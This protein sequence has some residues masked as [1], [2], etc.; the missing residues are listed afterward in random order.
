VR[1]LLL[2]VLALAGAC[3]PAHAL[4]CDR[5]SRQPLTYVLTATAT[6]GKAKTTLQIHGTRAAVT[7]VRIQAGDGSL[8]MLNEMREFAPTRSINGLTGA[9]QT[10]DLRLTS[11][12]LNLSELGDEGIYDQTTLV[13]GKP[14]KTE[15]VTQ[16]VTGTDTRVISGCKIPV[17]NM[18]R[19][20]E[21]KTTH[22]KRK[23]FFD[24]APWFG[25]PVNSRVE[26]PTP[27]G[28]HEQVVDVTAIAFE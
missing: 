18:E 12:S 16:R 27:E 11:G 10:F 2:S 9:I 8:D 14:V 17:L 23:S 20:F 3:A 5:L 28:I 1:R 26:V 21:D 25:F 7:I 24:Y 6:F 13:D 4:D 19:D 22:A 15:I